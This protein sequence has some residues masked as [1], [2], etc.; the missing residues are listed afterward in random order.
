MEQSDEL[1]AALAAAPE[2]I[3]LAFTKLETEHLQDLEKIR[4]L[5]QVISDMETIAIDCI[6]GLSLEALR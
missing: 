2:C 5:M 6:P 4:V 3:R 1:E